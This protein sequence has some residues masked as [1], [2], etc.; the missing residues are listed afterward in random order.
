MSLININ[1]A[2]PRIIKD[3]R[4]KKLVKSISEF[5]KMM[6]LRPIIVDRGGMILGGNMRFKALQ[7]LKYKDIPDEW[8]KRA[9]ELTEDEKRRFI[10]S[11]NVPFGEWD[12]EVLVN[13]WDREQ[14]AEWGL[15]FPEI[16]NYNPENK[17]K[18]IDQLNTEHECPSCGYKW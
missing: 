12:W 4:F 11:D 5:P 16:F 17:E 14:L 8:V 18:E 1:P 15:E 10:I 13:I 6:A 2:N 9:D 3:D 7:E